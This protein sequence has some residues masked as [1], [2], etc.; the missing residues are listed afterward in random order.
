MG[1]P[2]HKRDAL[3][4][5]L[6]DPICPLNSLFCD[7]SG[8]DHKFPDSQELGYILGGMEN[9]AVGWGWVGWGIHGAGLGVMRWQLSGQLWE[10]RLWA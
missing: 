10:E 1:P 5:I 8:S 2:M 3:L 4:C 6:E 9:T 7:L